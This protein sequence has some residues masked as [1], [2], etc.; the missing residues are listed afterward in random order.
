MRAKRAILV[1]RKEREAF[2]WRAQ[3]PR[4]PT[5]GGSG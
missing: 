2:A 4:S 1:L 5:E 3:I